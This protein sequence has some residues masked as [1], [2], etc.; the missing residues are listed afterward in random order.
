MEALLMNG[1]D[2]L[3]GKGDN[4]L[5]VERRYYERPWGEASES[6]SAELS[7]TQA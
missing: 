4:Q 7:S 2:K 1:L 3:S 5:L 6:A